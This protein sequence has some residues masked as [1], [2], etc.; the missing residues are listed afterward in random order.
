VQLDAALREADQELLDQQPVIEDD[1]LG[2]AGQRQLLVGQVKIVDVGEA[3]G[4]ALAQDPA[5][6]PPGHI[7]SARNDERGVSEVD[8]PDF[9]T[10][11]DSPPVAEVGGEAGLATMGDKACLRRAS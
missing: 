2:R 8:E 4:V 9:A 7:E 1:H 3:L 10:L 11:L 6:L 5:H